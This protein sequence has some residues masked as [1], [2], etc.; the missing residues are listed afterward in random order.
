M[1]FKTYGTKQNQTKNDEGNKIE[2]AQQRHNKSKAHGKRNHFKST[3]AICNADIKH[4][5]SMAF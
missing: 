5:F 3:K 4:E 2:I 1:G